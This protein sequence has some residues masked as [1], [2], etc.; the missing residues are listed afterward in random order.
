MHIVKKM[1]EAAPVVG[2]D[3]QSAQVVECVT[4]APIEQS[5]DDPIPP[6]L[7]VIK[8]LKEGIERT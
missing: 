2:E 5:V 3:V 8:S 1:I 4:P 7:N 6:L